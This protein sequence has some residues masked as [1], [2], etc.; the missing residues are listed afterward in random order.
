MDC[1]G[2]EIFVQFV[3]LDAKKF[4]LAREC[5]FSCGNIFLR[6]FF[7]VIKLAN[8]NHI[9]DKFLPQKIE[10]L[11]KILLK[12]TIIVQSLKIST[13]NL[14]LPDYKEVCGHYMRFVKIND[15]FSR[16]KKLNGTISGVTQ[17]LYVTLFLI[18]Y[19]IRIYNF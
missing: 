18:S 14:Q 7:F 13:N 19:V 6:Y 15:T 12:Y 3:G 11:F 16:S 10:Y 4:I 17:R 5:S 2:I 8:V 1:R 9:F